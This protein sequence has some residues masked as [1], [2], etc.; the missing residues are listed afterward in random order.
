MVRRGAFSCVL[1]FSLA[2]RCYPR[3]PVLTV[4][5][6]KLDTIKVDVANKSTAS[7]F[8]ANPGWVP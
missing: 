3:I 7:I 8:Q 4:Y 1:V 6:P 5:L 2:R